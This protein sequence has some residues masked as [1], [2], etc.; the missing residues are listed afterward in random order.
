MGVR[1]VLRC[2]ATMA[3]RR[4]VP[5]LALVA[6]LSVLVG[7]LAACGGSDRGEPGAVGAVTDETP[8][9]FTPGTSPATDTE[10]M[11][12]LIDI[13]YGAC[14]AVAP[15]S[16]PTVVVYPDGTIVRSGY[17]TAGGDPQ[18]AL[19]GYDGRLD[20][21][22]LAALVAEARAADLA[23]GGVG[24][25]GTT[26]GTADGGGTRFVARLDGM[27]TA[28]EVPFLLP[29][30]GSDPEA[31]DPQGGGDPEQR[32]ALTTV[33][34]H[35]RSLGTQV[36][37]SPRR[38]A[39]WAV[40]AAPAT[41]RS[42]DAAWSTP[43]PAGLDQPPG[44]VSDASGPGG[45]AGSPLRCGLL[46]AGDDRIA[47][48]AGAA[49]GWLTARVAGTVWALGAR[50]LLPHEHTCTDVAASVAAQHLTELAD[51]RGR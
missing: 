13:C 33:A 41:D 21:A 23:L 36:A 11:L 25:N 10:P 2:R 16:L 3:V 46:D 37:V 44:L 20:D 48:L 35:L 17:V 28:F 18:R 32:A 5:P 34:D 39:R 4:V 49:D 19:A 29:G 31:A 24:V 26:Q 47:E 30:D 50:P 12:E 1:A 9:P 40:L 14:G 51:L 8:A 22:T 27:E 6:A 42:P 15:G 7:L 45:E 38:G 43:D